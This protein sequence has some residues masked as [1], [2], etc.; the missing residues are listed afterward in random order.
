MKKNQCTILVGE[1]G[2]GKTTQ[3]PQFILDAGY[4]TYG[5]A[6]AC[7]QPRRVAAMSVAQRVADEMDVE[8]GTYCGYSIR[9]EDCTSKDTLLKYMTD[10]MLLREAMTDPEL[11]RWA[12]FRKLSLKRFLILVQEGRSCVCLF[13]SHHNL[14]VVRRS[15]RSSSRVVETCRN[16][17]D[18]CTRM[19]N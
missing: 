18:C 14:H 1:T 8:I 16:E 4:A 6:V 9:F 3:M 12:E 5:K 10:G 13:I 7:T 2:S 11:T 17:L 15:A 19:N